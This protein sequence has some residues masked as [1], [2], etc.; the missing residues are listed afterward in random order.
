MYIRMPYTYHGLNGKGF[1]QNCHESLMILQTNIQRNTDIVAYYETHKF[2][3]NKLLTFK[4]YIFIYMYVYQN[5]FFQIQVF[6]TILQVIAG[7]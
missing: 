4:I 6:L 5:V 3:S 2:Y 7:K 1:L